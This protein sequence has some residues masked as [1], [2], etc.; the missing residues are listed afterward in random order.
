MMKSIWHCEWGGNC[1]L[2]DLN[3]SP[4]IICSETIGPLP[5]DLS[6]QGEEYRKFVVDYLSENHAK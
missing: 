1:C 6:E 3:N 5:T 4:K 2:V